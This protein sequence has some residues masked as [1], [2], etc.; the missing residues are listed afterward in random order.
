MLLVLFFQHPALAG[1]KPVGGERL[2]QNFSELLLR[3]DVVASLTEVEACKPTVIQ[4]LAIPKILRGKN[5]LFASETGEVVCSLS[6]MFP[7]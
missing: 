7:S 2:V 3:E 6:P 1:G 4:M 5:V